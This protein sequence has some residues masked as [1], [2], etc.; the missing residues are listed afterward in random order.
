MKRS[1]FTGLIPLLFLLLPGSIHAQCPAI[2]FIYADACEAPDGKGEFLVLD[3]ADQ[4][5]SISDLTLVL[6]DGSK[7]CTNCD[8][9]WS[10]ADV[11]YLNEIANCGEL[12]IPL[13][14]KGTVPPYAKLL[15]FTNRQFKDDVDWSTFCGKQNFYAITINRVDNTNKYPHNSS[16]CGIKSAQVS[17]LFNNLSGCP[18][19]TVSYSPCSMEPEIPEGSGGGP[20]VV[21]DDYG[22]AIYRN[23][24]CDNFFM[25]AITLDAGFASLTGKVEGFQVILDW[26][27]HDSSPIAQFEIQSGDGSGNWT[28]V[29][30]QPAQAMAVGMHQ[31]RY[32]D[33]YAVSDKNFYRIAQIR[34]DGKHVF[35]QA[36]EISEAD[37]KPLSRIRMYESQNILMVRNG[38]SNKTSRVD[39][40]DAR[41]VSVQGIWMKPDEVSREISLDGLT[42]GVYTTV[43]V[44]EDGLQGTARF[45]KKNN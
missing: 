6:P 18:S 40:I 33:Q 38:N 43:F 37:M 21:F 31:F 17:V 8:D 34:A 13:S 44:D 22:A 3:N 15:I 32:K 36:I 2:S 24:G 27:M 29:T 19:T 45:I 12:F 35:S 25:D 1:F 30:Q 23:V 9:V 28:T 16:G 20:A 42:N 7:V 14:V 4:P 39:I 11:S 10:A 26:E 41:G 5:F